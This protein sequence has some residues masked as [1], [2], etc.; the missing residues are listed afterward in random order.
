MQRPRVDEERTLPETRQEEA[1][2][3]RRL[4]EGELDGNCEVLLEAD[5]RDS[6]TLALQ[7]F[8]VRSRLQVD[9]QETMG[10]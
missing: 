1:Q 5:L 3:R 6:L 9:I 10:R 4:R 2:S 8:L 7:R